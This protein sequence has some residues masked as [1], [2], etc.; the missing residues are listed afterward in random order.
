MQDLFQGSSFSPEAN[1]LLGVEERMKAD[2]PAKQRLS[3]SRLKIAEL[4]GLA[5]E[6]VFTSPSTEP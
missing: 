1:G 5:I 2:A 6:G 4:L 3:P